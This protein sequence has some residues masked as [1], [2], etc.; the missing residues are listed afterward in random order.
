M[1]FGLNVH[2]HS[3]SINMMA[4]KSMPAPMPIIGYKFE[5]LPLLEALT[6]AAAGVWKVGAFIGD[7]AK[8]GAAL[9]HKNM[10]IFTQQSIH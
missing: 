2:K 1:V 10:F 8:V 3:T 6:D 4:M 5:C 7:A 9:K